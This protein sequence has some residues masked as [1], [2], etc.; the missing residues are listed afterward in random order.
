MVVRPIQE[1]NIFFTPRLKG[2][3]RQSCIILAGIE[4]VRAVVEWITKVWQELI[5]A[6]CW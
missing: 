4:M 5:D 6:I 2:L 1:G 3:Y